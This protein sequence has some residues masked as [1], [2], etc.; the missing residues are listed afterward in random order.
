MK[1]LIKKFYKK[2]LMW[3]IY[4]ILFGVSMFLMLCSDVIS[5]ETFMN[6]MSS[7]PVTQCNYPYVRGMMMALAIIH[8]AGGVA[9]FVRFISSLIEK[10]YES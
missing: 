5:H 10:D 7:E 9:L 2:N 8:C 1:D 6:K 3:T 4:M